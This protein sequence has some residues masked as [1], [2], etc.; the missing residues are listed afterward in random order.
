MCEPTTILVGISAA[1][2]VLGFV[3]AQ[4][5]A[6]QQETSQLRAYE[7][8]VVESRAAF[9]RQ[10]NQENTRLNQQGVADSN[11]LSEV[12]L[13]KRKAKATARVAAGEAGVSGLS[14]DA[15]LGDFDRTEARYRDSVAQQG[16]FDH[17]ASQDRIADFAADRESRINRARPQP[18]ARPSF[19]GAALRVAGD[20]ASAGLFDSAPSSDAPAGGLNSFERQN[21]QALRGL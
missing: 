9:A 7:D 14:L 20:A 15:L 10:V 12:A 17:L 5:Q 13:R 6:N 3:G 1:S 4:Q 19:L 8:T 2:A 11:E 18:V 16:E 21:A